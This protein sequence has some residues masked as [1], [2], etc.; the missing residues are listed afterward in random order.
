MNAVSITAQKLSNAEFFRFV[1]IWA[2]FAVK[3]C[4]H[5]FLQLKASAFN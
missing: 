5:A 1:L 4:H 3:N 2:T